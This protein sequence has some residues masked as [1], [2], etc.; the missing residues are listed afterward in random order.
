PGH[1]PR[2]PERL[3]R[4]DDRN[5]DVLLV[6]DIVREHRPGNVLRDLPEVTGE[7]ECRTRD[8]IHRFVEI[9]EFRQELIERH[10][11]QGSRKAALAVYVD[12]DDRERDSRNQE[13]PV[14]ALR[15]LVKICDEERPGHDQHEPRDQALED[16]AAEQEDPD[17]QDTGDHHRPADRQPVRLGKVD[18]A[19][20]YQDHHQDG[21]EQH[22]VHAV[23]VVLGPE[24]GGGVLD[25]QQRK[26]PGGD[27]LVYDG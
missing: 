7:V 12:E 13:R 23:D 5:D 21:K 24:V 19:L 6:Y 8:L 18:G 11:L 14:T 2:H 22:P 17:D 16:I 3:L 20:E 15:D 26:N 25:P 1:P 10:R 27:A 9:V 4:A